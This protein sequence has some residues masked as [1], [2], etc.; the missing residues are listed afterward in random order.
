MN[1]RIKGFISRQMYFFFFDWTEAWLQA[2]VSYCLELT[3][4]V[5]AVATL[6]TQLHFR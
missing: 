1:K 2:H 5:A 3:A 4:T 6:Q